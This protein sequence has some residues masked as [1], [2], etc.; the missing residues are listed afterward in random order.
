MRA[1]VSPGIF[2]TYE[3][4]EG[5]FSH[6]QDIRCKATIIDDACGNYS[7][8]AK[9]FS[10]IEWSSRPSLTDKTVAIII[11]TWKICFAW[12]DFEIFRRDARTYE[13]HV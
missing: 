6:M 8:K 7:E 1:R 9:N 10:V 12:L 11:S 5:L 2:T 3:H 4:E 13:Q